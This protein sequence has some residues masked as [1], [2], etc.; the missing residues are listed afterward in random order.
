M[1][2]GF[3][4]IIVK[5]ILN[6]FQKIGKHCFGKNAVCC[7]YYSFKLRYVVDRGHRYFITYESPQNRVFRS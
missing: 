6:G 3:W 2:T 4:T 5:S 1:T 7:L